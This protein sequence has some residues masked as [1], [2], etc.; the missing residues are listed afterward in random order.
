[1]GGRRTRRTV[2]PAPP[3]TSSTADATVTQLHA[4]ASP[5]DTRQAAAL[6]LHECSIV[7]A[8]LRRYEPLAYA[9]AVAYAAE[10]LSRR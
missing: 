3:A 9:R 5:W 7:L 8:H 1:M 4:A 10:Y 6:T 2:P